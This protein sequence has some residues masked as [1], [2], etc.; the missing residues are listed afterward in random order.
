MNFKSLKHN[1]FWMIK[2]CFIKSVPQKLS[3][4]K[5]TWAI[6]ISCI[7]YIDVRMIWHVS[8]TIYLKNKARDYSRNCKLKEWLEDYVKNICIC[9]VNYYLDLK[10][11][12]KIDDFLKNMW[13]HKI[14]YLVNMYN[15]FYGF[16]NTSCHS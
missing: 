16:G 14:I 5:W 12:Y 15:W 11:I 8:Q 4:N 7:H 10:F 1:K 3:H 9:L 2:Y 6:I 13:A